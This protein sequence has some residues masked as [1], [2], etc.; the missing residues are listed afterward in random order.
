MKKEEFR[1]WL[2]EVDGRNAAQTS[3]HISRIKRIED[4]VSMLDNAKCDVEEECIKDGGI[5]L[6]DK[7]SLSS[8]KKMPDGINLPLTPMGM[9]RLRSSLRKYIDFFEWSKQ[10]ESI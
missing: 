7:L 9:S 10:F 2:K 5:S 6:L 1:R 8:R 3:D 4:A